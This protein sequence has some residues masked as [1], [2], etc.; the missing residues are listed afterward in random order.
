MGIENATGWLL[1][2]QKNGGGKLMPRTREKTKGRKARGRYLAMP[3][4]VVDSK[5]YR[6]LSLAASRVLTML[7]YQYRGANNGD[8]CAPLSEAKRWGINGPA[9]LARA[10]RELEAANLIV[11]TRDPTRLRKSPHG[12]CSLF[13]LTW[14]CLDECGGKHGLKPTSTPLRI[15]SGES[16]SIFSAS[17]SEAK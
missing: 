8:L 3:V 12:Q 14:E 5:S 16:D 13:A 11:R 9:T 6:E 15:F 2:A 17:K 4:A 10:L 7:H 1:A